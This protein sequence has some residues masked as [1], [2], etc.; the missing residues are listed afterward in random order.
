MHKKNYSRNT[1][2]LKVIKKQS[3]GK[4]VSKSK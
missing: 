2:F 1:K 4:Y 3:K